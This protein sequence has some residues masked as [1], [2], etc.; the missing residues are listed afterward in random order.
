LESSYQK[1]SDVESW[2]LLTGSIVM[3]DLG[4]FLPEAVMLKLGIFLPEAVMFNLGIF[5]P[6]A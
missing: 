1:L 2:N 6:E 4:I 5:L 3:L